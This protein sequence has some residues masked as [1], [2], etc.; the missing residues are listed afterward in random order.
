MRRIAYFFLL[1]M[2][3]VSCKAMV[4]EMKTISKIR[5]LSKEN[6]ECK[7]VEVDKSWEKGNSVMN[8]SLTGSWSEDHGLT[9]A[10]IYHALQDSFPN[11]CKY[12]KV[13]IIFLQDD[14]EEHIIYY[15]CNSTPDRDTIFFEDQYTED[16]WDTFMEDSVSV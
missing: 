5:R 10:H 11:I 7:F 1:A 16:E 2:V 15:D 3:L 12:G 14:F 13:S 9:A 6:C 8:I 4:N